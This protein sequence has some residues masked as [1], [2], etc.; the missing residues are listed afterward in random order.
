MPPK[1]TNQIN[2]RGMTPVDDPFYR[3]KMEEVVITAQKQKIIFENI[4]VICNNL[5]REPAHMIKYLKQQLG[6]AVD[7][8]NNV[9]VISKNI[10]KDDIQNVIYKYI[11]AFVLCK[12]C[13]NPET[14]FIDA[15]RLQC[16][17][18]SFITQL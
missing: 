15:K 4:D 16:G 9:A 18:C 3:Y 7:Y 1:K 10:S 6:I 12:S 2:V 14:T 8:K 11:D 17:A 13:K 5:S